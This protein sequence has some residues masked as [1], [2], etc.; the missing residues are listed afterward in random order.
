MMTLIHLTMD[1]LLAVRDGEGSAAA[2]QHMEECAA[3]RHEFERLHQRAAALKA[4]PVIAPPRDRWPMVRDVVARARRRRRLRGAGWIAMAAAASLAAALGLGRLNP[5]ER[6][7]ESD[8][9]VSLMERSQQIEGALRRFQP[10]TGVV[11]GRVAGAVAALEDEI[12]SVDARLAWAREL[13]LP[14]N[15]LVELW[16]ERVDL[17]DALLNVRATRAT[18]VGF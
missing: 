16:R 1:Q 9:L 3:C 5:A 4:M 6:A 12:S 13:D 10:E 2:R 18:Y 14:R 11:S 8:D 17:M 15:D 7:N